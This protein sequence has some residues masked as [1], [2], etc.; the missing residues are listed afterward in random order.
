M[1]VE[2]Y[3]SKVTW[4]KQVSVKWKKETKNKTQHTQIHTSAN[5]KMPTS[6]NQPQK[7]LKNYFWKKKTNERK[8]FFDLLVCVQNGEI[9]CS[10]LENFWAFTE[11]LHQ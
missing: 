5:A 6:N 9:E 10:Q 3:E 7:T 1:V 11:K 2:F 4:H 8:S